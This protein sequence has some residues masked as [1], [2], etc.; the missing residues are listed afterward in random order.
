ME[1]RAHHFVPQFYL[2]NFGTG[3]SIALYDMDT[4]THIRCA[5]IRGQCQRSHLYGKDVT[6]EKALGAIERMA[7]SAIAGII[8]TDLPPEIWS[9][10]HVNLVRFAALQYCRTPA[11]GAAYTALATKMTRALVPESMRESANSVE[12]SHEAPVL[13]MMATVLQAG[14]VLL[15]LDMKVFVNNTDVEFITSDSPTVLFNQWACGV[16]GWGVVGLA[17]QGLQVFLPLSPRHVV[18]LYD[19][20]IYAV[21]RDGSLTVEL[22]NVRDVVGI[23]RLQVPAAA[24][25]LYY[26]GDP[27]TAETV[28]NLPFKLRLKRPLDPTVLRAEEVGRQNSELITA[29]R[30]MPN[31]KLNTSKIRVRSSASKVSIQDRV[32]YREAAMRAREELEGPKGERYGLGPKPG[33]LFR[34][35]GEIE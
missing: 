3:K 24:K 33:T 29:Y 23:N 34:V 9:E 35:V 15:D 13:K 12:V 20:E 19:R 7:A 4:R 28:G 17:S 27:A 31:L 26:S 18:L 5:S 14:Y 30:E 2:R 1:Y 8:A 32:F 10:S 16:R 25:S 11:A 6:V 21:G 22:G